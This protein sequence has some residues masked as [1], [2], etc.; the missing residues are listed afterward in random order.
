MAR[1]TVGTYIRNKRIEAGISLR[2]LSAGLGVSPVYLGEV[3]RGV[4][5]SISR[6]RWDRLVELVPKLTMEGLE[7]H[8]ASSTPLQLD[9]TDAPPQYQNLGM[10]LAR[11]LKARDLNDSD[12]DELLRLLGRWEEDR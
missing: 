11:R 8:A 10:A 3:E 6:E 1:S 2:K 7:R 5:P 4:R 9:L 12:C